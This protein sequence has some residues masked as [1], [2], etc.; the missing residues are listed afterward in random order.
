[1]RRS[2]LIALLALLLGISSFAHAALIDNGGGLIYDTDR[3]ITWYVP[4]LDPMTW[5]QAVSWAAGLSVSNANVSNV[6]GWRL[7]SAPNQDGTGPCSGYICLESEMGHLYYT[8]LGNTPHG[9]LTNKGPFANLQQ[10]NYWTALE[11]TPFPGNAWAFGFESGLQGFADKDSAVYFFAMAVRGGNVGGSP[12]SVTEGVLADLANLLTQ[13]SDYRNAADLRRAVQHLTNSLDPRL[14]IDDNRPSPTLEQAVFAAHKSA[15]HQLNVLVGRGLPVQ[16]FI[17][18]LTAIDASL[19]GNA[20]KGAVDAFGDPVRI[21]KARAEMAGASETA[22]GSYRA[23]WV[24]ATKDT[25][26]PH[27]CAGKV[28]RECKREC[29]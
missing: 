22:I 13:T 19:A 1:M 23:A 11:W 24:Q 16:E 27:R 7:P 9:P 2:V 10:A 14:W 12:F 20:I 15:V 21:S 25:L 6:T 18:S 26:K 17:D 3:D 4:N 5:S 29:L 28:P 8:E